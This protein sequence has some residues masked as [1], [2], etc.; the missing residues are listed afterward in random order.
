MTGGGIARQFGLF[1]GVGVVNTLVDFA[2]FA[3][4]VRFLGIPPLPAHVAAYL[5][6]TANSFLMN[7]TMTFG[8]S[9]RD[10]M[11]WRL[12]VGFAATV[13]IQLALTSLVLAGTM[14]LGASP[15]LAKAVSIAVAI[16][17]NFAMSRHVFTSGRI[18]PAAREK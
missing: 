17:A 16:L 1:A 7:G 5:C 15:Y 4:L 14:A 13:A 6:G 10:I 18:A 3:V 12:V 2:V 8:R 9:L 11:R